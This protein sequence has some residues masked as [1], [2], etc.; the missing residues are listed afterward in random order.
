MTNSSLK[1]LFNQFIITLAAVSIFAACCSVQEH[2]ETYDAHKWSANSRNIEHLQ[3]STVSIISPINNEAIC[4]GFF[5]SPELIM[6]ARHCYDQGAGTE[7][8]LQNVYSWVSAQDLKVITYVDFLQGL[9]STEGLVRMTDVEIIKFP[10][11]L[12]TE[13]VPYNK[14]DY[15][16]LKLKNNE[17]RSNYWLRMA[18]KTPSVG[19]SVHAVSLPMNMPWIYTEGVVSQYAYDLINYPEIQRIVVDIKIT[20]GSSGSPL[21][22]NDGELVGL[23]SLMHEK[24]GLAFY[25]PVENMRSFVYAMKN[26]RTH[27]N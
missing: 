26:Q 25:I 24:T 8:E 14:N 1:F 18:K 4:S 23:L 12:P 22:N 20:F 11:S 19:E 10:L 5:I 15:I 27:S 17:P 3:K 9:K 13:S 6:T 2:K 16:L 7:E 21:V